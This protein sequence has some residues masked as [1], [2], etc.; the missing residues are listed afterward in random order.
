MNLIKL[1]ENLQQLSE[2]DL[3]DILD[4]RDS[5]EFD[6][7]WSQL[8]ECVQD[9]DVKIGDEAIFKSLS[10]TLSQHEITSYIVDDLLVLAKVKTM[11]IESALYYYQ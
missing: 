10:D 9:V 5:K 6:S 8:L 3:D 2:E 1:R 11:G 4:R 7:A